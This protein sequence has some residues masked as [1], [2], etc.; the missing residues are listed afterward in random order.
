MKKKRLQIL[1]IGALFLPACLCSLP[2][3]VP[4]I[5]LVTPR[6]TETLTVLPPAD[7]YPDHGSYGLGDPFYP[8]LGNGGYDV[9]NYDI[10]LN[11]HMDENTINGS[12][13][14]MAL[15]SENLAAFNLDFY[16]MNILLV[17]VN[18]IN[19]QYSRSGAELTVIPA[20]ALKDGDQFEVRVD[21]EGTP[22]PVTDPSLAVGEGIGW[23]DFTSGIYTINEP[24]G[25][26]SWF[27]SNNYP[28]DKATYTFRVTVENP[29]VVAA[30]GLLTST[31]ASGIATTY[32]WE[33]NR[34]MASYLASVNIA[35]FNLRTATGPDGLLIRNFFESS[36][37]EQAI[38]PYDKL[39]DMIKFYS[40]LIA[41]YP[42][43]AYG[44]VVMPEAVGVAMENQTL[45]VFGSDMGFEEAI[46]HELAHQWFGDS[47]TLASWHDIWLNEGFATY[48]SWL[49][50]EY[51]EGK[52]VFKNYVESNYQIA[53]DMFPPGNPEAS[54]IFDGSVYVRGGL[55]LHALR[56]IVGDATFYEILRTYYYRYQLSNASTED[57]IGVAQEVSGSDLGSFF[58]AWLYASPIPPLPVP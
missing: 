10:T 29:Y 22:Q 24:S 19:A 9:L 15:A 20:A 45:S 43:E 28:T 7:I 36:L 2:V 16:G 1:V 23:L 46:A 40:D 30:N 5:S 49:W 11:V 17:Q 56:L 47:V 53:R 25:S 4:S 27:P 58:N 44:V 38:S 18:Y 8:M 42:F 32:T 12:A 26:M 37:N 14:I 33:E 6:V 55:A 3:P 13:I 39:S 52:D 50:M 31:N 21:Y 41:P 51:K 57:F 35:K 54:E 34:P 48:L